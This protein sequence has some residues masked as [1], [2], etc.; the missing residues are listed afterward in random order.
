MRRLL[1]NIGL[2]LKDA[3][4]ERA[5]ERYCAHVRAHHPERRVPSE[6]E[7]YLARLK[8]KYT[9]PSRCC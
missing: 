1:K 8:E 5:Y 7:F 9:R 3:A 2:F 6:K 4:G